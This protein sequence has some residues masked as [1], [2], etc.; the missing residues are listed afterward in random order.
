MLSHE[1][2]WDGGL[3]TFGRA[4]FWHEDTPGKRINFVALTQGQFPQG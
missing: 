2:R 3:A 4:R 1:P